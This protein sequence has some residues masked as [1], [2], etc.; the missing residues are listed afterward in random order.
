MPYPR[1]TKCSKCGCKRTRRTFQSAQWE[2]GGVC[3]KC[4]NSM[5]RLRRAGNLE[6]RLRDSAQQ[7]ALR[8]KNWPQHLALHCRRHDPQS[9][10]TGEQIRELHRRQNGRCYWF[11]VQ[12]RPDPRARYPAKPSVDRLDNSKPHSLENCVLSCFA[13]NIGRNSTPRREWEVFLRELEDVVRTF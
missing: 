7:K 13:A 4:K 10:L 12:L 2:R 8:A 6:F 11:G 9:T 1:A 5:R 3:T